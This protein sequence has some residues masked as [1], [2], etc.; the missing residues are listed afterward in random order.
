MG[1]GDR[2]IDAGS[3]IG[4]LRVHP[5]VGLRGDPVAAWADFVVNDP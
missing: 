4:S 5:N 1:G 3:A 2:R